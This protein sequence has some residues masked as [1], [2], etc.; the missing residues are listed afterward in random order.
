MAYDYGQS[1]LR[2]LKDAEALAALGR[3]DNAGHL[4]GLAVECALKHAARG[5]TR[6]PN[7]SIDGHLP[8]VKFAIRTLLNGRGA[9]G[10]LLSLVN[11]RRFFADW[12]ITTRYESD[13]HVDR[14]KYETWRSDATKAFAVARL[15]AA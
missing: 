4:I 12:S 6:P 7:E 9:G 1:A 3:F 11:S 15:R 14:P 5:F 8:S 13:G 2:H 10:P